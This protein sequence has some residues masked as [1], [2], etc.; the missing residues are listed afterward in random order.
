VHLRGDH[1][2]NDAP[3]F[4]FHLD[5][6]LISGTYRTTKLSAVNAG[7]YHHFIVTIFHLGKQQRTA[8]LRNASTISTPGMI[9]N[10]GKWPLKNGS[11]MVTFLIAT[12]LSL[13]FNS[14]TR[15]ISRKG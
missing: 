10:P 13:R 2:R 11:L 4:H 12:M 3:A 15:S 8:R 6:K 7:E 9:G 14:S 1:S 5:P